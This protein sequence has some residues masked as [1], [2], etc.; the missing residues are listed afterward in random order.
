[1]KCPYFAIWEVPVS[2]ARIGV[3]S[4]VEKSYSQAFYSPSMFQV[5]EYCKGIS[6]KRCPFYLKVYGR[7]VSDGPLPLKR[8]VGSQAK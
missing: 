1:M 4:E 5:K 3:C 8:A 6:Y 2:K 7:S